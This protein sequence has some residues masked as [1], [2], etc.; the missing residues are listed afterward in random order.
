MFDKTMLHFPREKEY[1]VHGAGMHG[2][3]RYCV[4]LRCKHAVSHVLLR[5]TRSV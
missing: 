2:S 5:S 4:A 1:D 3:D